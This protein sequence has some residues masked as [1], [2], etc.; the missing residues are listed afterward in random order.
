MKRDM[1]RIAAEH[2]RLDA[3]F[4]HTREAFA[5][6]SGAATREALEALERALETHFAQEDQLYYPAIAALRSAHQAAVKTF[7][8]NHVR[9]LAQLE[10]IAEHAA[11]GRL[12]QAAAEFEDLALSFSRHEAAE[13]D[14]LRA[15]EGELAARV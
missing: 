10:S 8:A 3:L 11:Q 9:F 7:A 1:H 15:I 6:G 5:S 13:E 2:R 14:L 4:G 12:A